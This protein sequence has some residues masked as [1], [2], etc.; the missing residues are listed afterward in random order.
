MAQIIEQSDKFGKIG[1]AF[2]QGLS[3]Q[4]PKEVERYRLSEGLKN[5][6][7]EAGG[8]T[9]LQ[10]QA[11]LSSIPGITPQMI[12]S[13]G[14][15]ASQQARSEALINKSG[16]VGAENPYRRT[17]QTPEASNSQTPSLTTTS[18][19]EATLNPYI[20]KS[21]DQ[22]QQRA[23]EL[24]EQSPG[25]YAKNPEKAMDAAV[26]EENQAKAISDAKQNQR[27][28]QQ[29]VQ[30]KIE[31]GLQAQAKR[32]N[33]NVPSSVYNSIEDKAINSVKPKSEGGEGLTEHQ[34]K[35][36]YGDELE[37]VS[38]DYQAIETIGS[39]KVLSKKPKDNKDALRSIQKKFKERDDLENLASSYIDKNNLSPSKA[40]YLSYPVSDNKELNNK[41]E[42]LPTIP[43]T[44][45]FSG[46]R[47]ELANVDSEEKTYKVIPEI[48]KFMSKKD[49]P[50][51]IAE[52]LKSK[53]YDP[54]IWMNYLDANRKQLDLTER[55]AREL[56]YPR[57]FNDTINDLWMFYFSG[58]D[59]LVEQK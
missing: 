9:P 17:A 6:E 54:R 23:G 48:A 31:Q 33:A 8:L 58:L 7:Q 56:D 16:G 5:F 49:S 14:D 27:L 44:V 21:L 40:Y 28:S 43:T 39:W 37:S 3:E 32:S 41:I 55:Q 2:G 4:I 30:E 22:L 13:F 18:P 57:D 50:L 12:Q 42:K 36:K 26:L 46:G 47:P 10:Q 34:A 51:S 38:K 59:K 11:R 20:P 24:L 25:L 29:N 45:Q 52:E 35:K 19:I 15:L 1:K 53:G